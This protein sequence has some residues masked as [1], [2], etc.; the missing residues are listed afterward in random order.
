[1]VERDR[2]AQVRDDPKARAAG[3]V[4][5]DAV[6]PLETV[7]GFVGHARRTILAAAERPGGTVAE[8][9]RAFECTDNG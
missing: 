9:C 8:G 5:I 7:T 1:M 6:A 2:Q 3:L 4:S